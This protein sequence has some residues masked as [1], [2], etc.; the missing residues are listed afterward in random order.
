MLSGRVFNHLV[1]T[2]S[3]HKIYQEFQGLIQLN[4]QTKLLPFSISREDPKSHFSKNYNY[5]FFSQVH[6]PHAMSMLWL[7][8]NQPSRWHGSPLKTPMEASLNTSLS[9]SQSARGA[10][11]LG[12]TPMMESRPPKMW[13]HSTAARCTSSE[14]ELSPKCQESGATSFKWWHKGTV[15]RSIVREDVFN[16]SWDKVHL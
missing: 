13:R 6:H 9:T 2:L 15:S 5:F 10:L 12:W 16:M 3:A 11:T 14:W 1:M 7:S 8:P 4:L